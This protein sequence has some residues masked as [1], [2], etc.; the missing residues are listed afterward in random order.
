MNSTD[1]RWKIGEAIERIRSRYVHIGRK[2]GAPF[3]A[4]IYPPEAELAFMNEWHTLTD[5]LRPDFEVR[6]VNV[7]DVTQDLTSD[8][9]VTEIVDSLIDPMPGSDPEAELGNMWVT[10]VAN[11][12]RES[13]A[14]EGVGKPVVSVERLAALYPVAGPRDLMQRLWDSAQ[15]SL[16]GPVIVLIPGTITEPR[17]YRFL[18]KRT[19]FMYRGDVL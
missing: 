4:I 15:A 17:T 11:A 16:D 10:S 18:S 6:T 8:I 14:T 1:W 19:E 12:V 7:L 9:G 3:L 13:L 5:S 2:T